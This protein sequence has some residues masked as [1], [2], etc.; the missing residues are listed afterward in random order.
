[1]NEFPFPFWLAAGLVVGLG[2]LFLSRRREGYGLPACAVLATAGAWYLGDALYNDYGEY[3]REFGPRIL[4]DAWWQVVLFLLA[5]AVL[6]KP[7]H[8]RIN[9]R[10]AGRTSRVCALMETNFL[11]DPGL[12][13]KISR[14]TVVV[15]GMWVILM[16]VALWRVQGNFQGLFFPYLQ[17]KAEPWARGRIGGGFD[18]VISLAAYVQIFLTAAAGLAL[19]LSKKAWPR[20][21]A[22][23]IVLLGVPYYVFDRTRNTMLAV[24]LPG[25]LAWTFLRLKGGIIMKGVV[26]LGAF[27]AINFWF[28]LV[29][30]YRSDTSITSA[31]AGG[32][33]Q[34]ISEDKSIRHLGF[35]M[36]QELAYCNVLI[37]TGQYRV[38]WG[39]RYFAEVVNPIPR[40]LWKGKPLIGLDYAFA[41]GFGWGQAEG[42]EG[43]VAATI[44]TGMIGQ[45][46]VNFGVLMGPMAAALLMAIWTAM[47]ARQDLQAEDPVRLLL[48]GMGMIL[49]FN[50]GRDITLIT[51]YPFFFGWMLLTG[52][53]AWTGANRQAQRSG[54][55]AVRGAPARLRPEQ[56]EEERKRLRGG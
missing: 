37:E 48:Y 24:L 5:F 15:F 7:I 39:E 46:V 19:A 10:L 53:Q 28:A 25:I 33:A 40:V 1:V 44:S 9:R 43:G 16:L 14:A 11:A 3:L 8:R 18:A 50:L 20:T 29:I 22:L 26:L 32:G 36:F 56:I 38:N 30:K 42:K 34:K 2:G 35:N 55:Q 52:W 17:G 4:E 13:Q 27:L 12:Q 45:G 41:R 49:T 47:L 51:L 23:T 6:V 31:V 54:R 21:L